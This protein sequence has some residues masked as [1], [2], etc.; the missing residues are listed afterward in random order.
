MIDKPWLE[1][2]GEEREQKN[3]EIEASIVSS[4]ESPDKNI[5]ERMKKLH[6]HKMDTW[7]RYMSPWRRKGWE[8]GEK[9]RQLGEDGTNTIE[10]T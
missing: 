8:G 1:S 7:L 3:D 6:I 10:K 9:Q 5:E 2:T 4:F